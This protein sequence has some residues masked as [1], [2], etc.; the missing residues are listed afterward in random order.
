M[1]QFLVKEKVCSTLGAVDGENTVRGS[2]T[3]SSLVL[4][5]VLARESSLK[6]CYCGTNFLLGEPAV[7]CLGNRFFLS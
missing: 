7:N 2:S 1:R 5:T 6:G 3:E 4:G